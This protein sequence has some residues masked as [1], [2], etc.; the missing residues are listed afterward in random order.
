MTFRLENVR[1]KARLENAESSDE[2]DDEDAIA[3]TGPAPVAK[4]IS[5][6][7]RKSRISKTR[8]KNQFSFN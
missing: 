5:L 1:L 6:I 3:F 7:T 4:A 2:S 8:S